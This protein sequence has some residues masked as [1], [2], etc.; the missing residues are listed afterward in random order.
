MT[1]GEWFV[2]AYNT[3]SVVE[4]VLGLVLGLPCAFLVASLFAVMGVMMT[5]GLWNAAF[6]VLLILWGLVKMPFERPAPAV[7]Q[8]EPRRRPSLVVAPR[9][10]NSVEPE[11]P[12]SRFDL[13]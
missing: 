4:I 8:R 10:P 5:V 2:H 6:E 7:E 11:K 12:V 3:H 1:W 9:A 13:V